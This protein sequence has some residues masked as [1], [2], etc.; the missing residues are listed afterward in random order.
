MIQPPA[1]IMNARIVVV[2]RIV[3]KSAKGFEVSGD[4]AGLQSD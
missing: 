2:K 3:N 4:D 1:R